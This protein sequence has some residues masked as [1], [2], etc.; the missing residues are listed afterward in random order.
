MDALIEHQ[1]QK[2]IKEW[3]VVWNKSPRKGRINALDD[4]FPFDRHRKIAD[5]LTRAQASILV[6]LRTRH[7]PLNAYLHKIGK[8]ASSRCE[9]CWLRSEQNTEETV[10]HFLFECP[11]YAAER[12]QLQTKL[13]RDARDLKTILKNKEKTKELIRY[14]ART[15]RLRPTIGNL[16]SQDD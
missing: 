14:I 1:R 7:I 15:K 9:A 2:L 16:T 5:T 8:A 4:S 12:S 3:Q 11:E 10:R 13:G 6:Q